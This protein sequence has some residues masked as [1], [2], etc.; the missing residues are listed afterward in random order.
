MQDPV[1]TFVVLK[2]IKY[3]ARDEVCIKLIVKV[4]ASVRD[5]IGT[6]YHRGDAK[7]C[8]VIR[9]FGTYFTGTYVFLLVPRE[10][11]FLHD[12][13]RYQNIR[14]RDPITLLSMDIVVETFLEI[15]VSHLLVLT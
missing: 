10:S 13:V 9:N 7:L 6:I 14:S 11:A 2:M 4:S 3:C 15:G 12:S 5:G 8:Y 1:H